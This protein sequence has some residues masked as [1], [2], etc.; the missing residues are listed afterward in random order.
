M[1]DG[2]TPPFPPPPGD[3]DWATAGWNALGA[4]I[5]P[6]IDPEQ[7]RRGSRIAVRPFDLD[8]LIKA[9]VAILR[10]HWRALLGV[11]FVLVLPY[12]LASAYLTRETFGFFGRLRL[13]ETQSGLPPG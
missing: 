13:N 8:A 5:V 11:T 9:S 2:A 10:L 7:W 3:P 12:S 1:T 4:P 6:P